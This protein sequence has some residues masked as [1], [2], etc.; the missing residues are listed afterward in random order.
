[1]V[2]LVGVAKDVRE[3]KRSEAERDTLQRQV[4]QASKLASLGE[5]AAGGAPEINHP[6]TVIKGNLDYFHD[7]FEARGE[8]EMVGVLRQ[9]EVAIERIVSIVNGLRVYARRDDGAAS[10]LDLHHLIEQSVTMIQQIFVRQGVRVECRLEA[11]KPFV[12][13]NAGRFQQVLMN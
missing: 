10:P 12:S 6:L 7:W 8:R 13:G 3:K 5:I 11:L 2:G 1:V 4:L 9:Q